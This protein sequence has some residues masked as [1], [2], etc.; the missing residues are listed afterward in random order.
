MKRIG[1]AGFGAVGVLLAS[2]A[3]ATSA[4]AAEYSITALPQLGRCVLVGKL[5]GEWAGKNCQQHT[6]PKKGSYEW[7][8]GAEKKK[9]EGLT[10]ET[11]VLEPSTTAAHRIGCAAAT[12]DGE[13]TGAKTETVTVDLIGCTLTATHQKCQSNPIPQKEGEIEFSVGGELGFIKSGEKPTAGW[14]LKNI[15]LNVTCG[16]FP[17]TN[18]PILK[19]TGSVIAQEL[20]VGVMVKEETLKYKSTAGKQKPE[21]F[22]GGS[23]DVLSTEFTEGLTTTKEQT[24]LKAD[25]LTESEE[26]LEIKMKCVEKKLPCT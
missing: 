23:T 5:K 17:E 26:L 20:K 16:Q 18:I 14:D 25:I 22:A 21:S 9:F 19:I 13:Y 12:Y 2:L 24:G 1:I 8:E 15:E 4:V 10:S 7:V 11:V 3:L 6:P